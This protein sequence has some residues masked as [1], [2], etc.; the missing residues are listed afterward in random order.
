LLFFP[1]FSLESEAF[2]VYL[3]H[4]NHTM[5]AEQVLDQ[6]I[7]D[8]KLKEKISEYEGGILHRLEPEWASENLHFNSWNNTYLNLAVYSEVEHH[9]QQL[10]KEQGQLPWYMMYF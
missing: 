4:N 6:M 10:K 1:F 2:I 5:T 3:H 7:A 9:E 8:L